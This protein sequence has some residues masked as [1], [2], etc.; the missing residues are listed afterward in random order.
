MSSLISRIPPE[1]RL[2]A[3]VLAAALTQ[4]GLLAAWSL[5]DAGDRRAEI[6]RRAR[7]QARQS[8]ETGLVNQLR[9]ELTASERAVRAELARE[10]P[11][12][13]RVGAALRAGV[14]FFVDAF[15]MDAEGAVVHW[16]RLPP[17]SGELG[18]RNAR[19]R[20]RL[21]TVL[22][23]ERTDARACVRDALA[24]D[25]DVRSGRDSDRVAAALALQSGW[26]AA[27]ADGDDATALALAERVLDDYRMLRDD[28]DG[29]SGGE[30]LGVSAAALVCEVRL[31]RLTAPDHE[32]GARFVDAVLKRRV[33]AQRLGSRISPAA[34]RVEVEECKRLLA[35]STVRWNDRERRLESGLAECDRIDAALVGVTAVRPSLRLQ[36]LATGETVAVPGTSRVSASLLSALPLAAGSGKPGPVWSSVVLLRDVEALRDRAIALAGEGLPLPDGLALSVRD[37]ARAVVGPRSGPSLIE[38]I[39][40]GEGTPSLRAGAV[41]VN[42]Q[43]LYLEVTEDRRKW[44]WVLAG[45]G[46]AVLAASL[47]A[48]RAVLRETRIA[49][50][51]GDFVSSLSH[52]LRTPLTSLRMFVET[53]QEGR[54]RD[55]AEARECLDV[56]ANETERLSAFVDRI[57]QFAAFSRGRAPIALQSAD[58]GELVRRAVAVYGKRAEAVSASIEVQVADELPESI[59]DRDA[60]QQVILNLLDNAVKHGGQTADAAVISTQSGGARVRVTVEAAG[61]RVRILVED[62][63]P[64]VP[65]RESE[66]IFEEFYRG[67][68][69]LA[70]RVQGTGIGLALARRIVLAH[71][72]SIA[73]K[74]SK[75]LGGACFRVTLPDASRGRAL[76]IAAAGQSG[77]ES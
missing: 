20:S 2:A 56:I 22:E 35:S 51:K 6:D 18:L 61:N 59:V 5:R 24:M 32:E 62:D 12:P 66:L 63:G 4:V 48:V 31:E 13:Q 34:Y 77:G 72:G 25:G 53:L 46:L 67:D 10:G 70:R 73:V 9:A 60:L 69:S 38:E 58:V 15:L 19:A 33:Q 68:E 44:L 45:A 27:L 17:A 21:R 40:L 30:P 3:I 26:R 37:G 74:R 52:E 42:P 11:A 50:M 39:P 41:V 23:L 64:G 49:R 54:V 7:G 76:A 71:G 16:R 28:R 29:M 47:L 14:P 43:A 57:L 65:D 36:A 75:G 55:E 1:S 8:I